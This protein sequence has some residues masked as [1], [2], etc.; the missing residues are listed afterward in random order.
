MKGIHH[1]GLSVSNLEES[2]KFFCKTLGW[3][4]VR[5]V[6]EYPAVFVTNEAVM[7]TLWQTS[8][9]ANAFDR[10]NNVGLHHVALLVESEEEL[11]L[12]YEKLKLA[13]GVS[14]EFAPE[15]L[16]EGP[17]KHMICYDPSGIRIELI[18]VPE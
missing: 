7:F 4:E 9:E 12:I 6:E 3:R 13:T 8:S 10:R 1:L 16:R 2:C 11:L 18:W 17:A 15:F 14:I 5:R